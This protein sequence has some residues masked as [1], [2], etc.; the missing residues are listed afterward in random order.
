[1]G[2]MSGISEISANLTNYGISCYPETGTFCEFP[3]LAVEILI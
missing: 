3:V 1:V 2:A